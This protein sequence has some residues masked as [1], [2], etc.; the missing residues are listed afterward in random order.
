MKKKMLTLC[1]T[2]KD[3]KVLLGMKK[4]GFGMGRWNGFGGKVESGE[5]LEEA[6]QR[7]MFEECGVRVE[8]MERVGVHEF[9]FE[10]NPDEVMIVS[11]FRVDDFSGTPEETE[12]M[13]PRWFDIDRIPY[14][15]MWPDDIFWFPL[16]LQGKKFYGAF[17]FGKGDAILSQE[18][19]EVDML[20]SF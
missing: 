20:P 19:K 11:I 13:K 15:D 12:E 7:E 4:R 16:F 8:R 18:L 6:A 2:V 1:V 14:E 5:T 9:V 3:R 10:A 17:R